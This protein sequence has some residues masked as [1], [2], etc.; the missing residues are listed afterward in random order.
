MRQ[1]GRYTGK[2]KACGS[3]APHRGSSNSTI[4]QCLVHCFSKLLRQ[5]PLKQAT[6]LPLFGSTD[7][8]HQRVHEHV[9]LLMLT[10]LLSGLSLKLY[11]S[12]VPPLKHSNPL[13]KGQG[14]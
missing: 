9:H 2:H 3:S 14:K 11:A 12:D 5:D 6:Q 13:S 7:E 1:A 8:L 4:N 10:F